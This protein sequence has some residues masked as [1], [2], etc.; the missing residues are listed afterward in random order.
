MLTRRLLWVCTI[1][2][3]P[4][5]E[6]QAIN[7]SITN[8]VYNISVHNDEFKQL[9]AGIEMVADNL[10]ATVENQSEQLEQ[11]IQNVTALRGRFIAY[12][13]MGARKI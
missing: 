11:L 9:K 3:Y 10:K 13:K 4:F 7:R 8:F 5:Y 2:K 6:T 1:S 12:R